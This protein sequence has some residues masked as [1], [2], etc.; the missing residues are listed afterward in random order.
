MQ[1][2]NIEENIDFYSEL[3]KLLNEEKSDNKEEENICLIS[4]EKL[5]NSFVKLNCGHSFNY[6]PL[7]KDLVNQKQK[8]NSMEITVLK[9]NEIRCPYCRKTQQ[10]ILPY[11]Q[12]LTLP[13]I[14]GVN[15]I[16]NVKINMCQYS[17]PNLNFNPMLPEDVTIGNGQFILCLNAGSKIT[18]KNYGDNKNYCAY[19]KKIVIHY[20]KE[21]L[22]L[23]KLNQKEEK[24]YKKMLI[25][26]GKKNRIIITK[27]FT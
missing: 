2:Y 5:T 20:A 21:E 23:L 13:K 7:Y 26:T 19:H 10:G 11:Y 16:E 17:I 12:E 27:I 6:L 22:K 1:K 15:T 24:K 4:N 25:V 8:F 3:H 9:K 18:G 14:N